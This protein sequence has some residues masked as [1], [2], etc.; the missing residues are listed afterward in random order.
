MTKTWLITGTSSGFGRHMTE[1]LLERGDRVVATIRRPGALADL[2][3]RHGERLLVREL[4]VTD[5][6]RLRAVVDE[7]WATFGRVDVVVSNAGYGLFGAAEELTDEQ[8]GAQ[9]ATNL[10]AP[11]QLA[12]AALPHLR[13][14]GGGA[15]LQLSS[16]SGHVTFPALSLYNASKFA[17]EGFFEALSQEVGAFGVRVVIVEPGSARTEFTGGSSTFG[18]A[19]AAYEGTPAGMLRARVAGAHAAT[20]EHPLDPAKAVRAMIA[21]A[22]DPRAPLRLLL[23]SDAY[24]GVRAALSDRLAAVEAQRELTL[25]VDV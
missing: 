10:L 11:I 4:D 7:A 16:L 22:D 18:P 6:E 3:E 17:V 5:T 20:D 21:A 24:A 1:Q 23:G 13:E 12:R 14:Q 25:S 9:L 8:I 15:F 2:A 19:L